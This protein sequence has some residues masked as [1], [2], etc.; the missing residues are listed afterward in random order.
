MQRIEKEGSDDEDII[1]LVIQGKQ[2]YSPDLKLS[3]EDII[4]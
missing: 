2:D 3:E 1:K 4:L